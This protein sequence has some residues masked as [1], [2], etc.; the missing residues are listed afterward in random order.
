MK[1]PET[2]MIET[3]VLAKSRFHRCVRETAGQAMIEYALVLALVALVCFGA[4]AAFR[5]PL[6][7]IFEAVEAGF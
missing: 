5:A 4:L 7:A 1:G 6:I 3:E 2:E